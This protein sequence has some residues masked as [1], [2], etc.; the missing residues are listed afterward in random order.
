MSWHVNA[1]ESP[2][3]QRTVPAWQGIG[4]S[5]LLWDIAYSPN[6]PLIPFEPGMGVLVA[7]DFL[8]V[9]VKTGFLLQGTWR[10]GQKPLRAVAT[11][12]Y[13]GQAQRSFEAAKT[14]Y[15]SDRGNATYAQFEWQQLNLLPGTFL[16]FD[17]VND[18]RPMMVSKVSWDVAPAL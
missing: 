11:L 2:P 15:W 14:N 6:S 1:V 10:A 9:Q 13:P 7:Q 5:L 3:V 18:S 4:S 16:T 8:T 17:L 12:Y